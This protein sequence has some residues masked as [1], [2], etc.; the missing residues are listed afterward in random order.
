MYVYMYQLIQYTF[1]EPLKHKI[2]GSLLELEKKIIPSGLSLK[3]YH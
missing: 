3:T 2:D 1:V